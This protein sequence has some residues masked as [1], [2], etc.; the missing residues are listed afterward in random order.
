MELTL[1]VSKTDPFRK[2]IK[3]TIASTEDAG[4]PFRAMERL[5]TTDTHRPQHA[6]LFCIGQLE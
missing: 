5:K 3:L 6:P 2:G 1:P 4:C